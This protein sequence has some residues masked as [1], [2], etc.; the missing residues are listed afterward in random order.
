[1]KRTSPQLALLWIAIQ[2]GALALCAWAM[3]QHAP[4]VTG[5]DAPAAPPPPA[6]PPRA[7]LPEGPLLVAPPP[8]ANHMPAYIMVIADRSTQ[9]ARG[10]VD[11]E[12]IS[13]GFYP[14]GNIRMVDVDGSRYE[15]RA[16]SARAEMRE[17]G[18]T[19]TF[20]LLVGVG[21]DGHLQATFIGGIHDS[22]TV[23]LETVIER[24]VL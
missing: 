19:R 23:V 8:S 6:P 10:N 9:L 24:S 13:F 12:W 16:V 17:A 15:G 4:E 1:M 11:G 3:G 2:L 21:L 20:G 5:D 7:P 18:G 14:D 22:E